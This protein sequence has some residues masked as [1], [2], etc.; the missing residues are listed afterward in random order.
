MQLWKFKKIKFKNYKLNIR[1]MKTNGN[2]KNKN[3]RNKFKSYTFNCITWKEKVW[4]KTNSWNKNIVTTNKKWSKRISRLI[5][6]LADLLRVS[7]YWTRWVLVKIWLQVLA[8]T[9]LLK[10]RVVKYPIKIIDIYIF[11]LL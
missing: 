9:V 3:Y 4:I 1:M 11:I 6:W 7:Y 2:M 5:F 8:R 10:G